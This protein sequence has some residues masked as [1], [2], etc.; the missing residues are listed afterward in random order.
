MT[1]SHF[2]LMLAIL[3]PRSRIAATWPVSKS[4]AHQVRY[5]YCVC[6]SQVN[7]TSTDSLGSFHGQAQRIPSDFRPVCEEVVGKGRR[8]VQA[9]FVGAGVSRTESPRLGEG[10]RHHHSS[11]TARPQQ[12]RHLRPRNIYH[13]HLFILRQRGI[14]KHSNQV[15]MIR[16]YGQQNGFFIIL[17][18]SKFLKPLPYTTRVHSSCSMIRLIWLSSVLTPGHYIVCVSI[19][20]YI[21]LSPLGIFNPIVLG[22]AVPAH[23]LPPQTPRRRTPRPPFDRLACPQRKGKGGNGVGLGLS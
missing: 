18:K 9:D 12:Q 15:I 13:G 16:I 20:I 14:D 21:Y 8:K 7:S 6:Q 3:R 17:S 11:Q 2:P 19:Y 4:C 5:V 22:D 1:I 23:R 10:A